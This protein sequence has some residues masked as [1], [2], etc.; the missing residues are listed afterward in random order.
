MR[1]ERITQRNAEERYKFIRQL[2]NWG[3]VMPDFDFNALFNGRKS[4]HVQHV[5]DAVNV[6]I[7]EANQA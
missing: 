2:R 5:I 4:M 1:P 7:N 6:A 3:V